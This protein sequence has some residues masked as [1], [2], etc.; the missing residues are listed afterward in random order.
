MEVAAQEVVKEHQ[1]ISKFQSPEERQSNFVCSCNSHDAMGKLSWFRKG[2]V[3]GNM[4][5]KGQKNVAGRHSPS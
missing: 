2:R 4:L 5:L 1:R 3:G